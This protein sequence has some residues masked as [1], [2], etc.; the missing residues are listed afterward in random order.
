MQW[1]TAPAHGTLLLTREPDAVR[2][3][4]EWFRRTLGVQ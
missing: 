4:V 3:L 1:L 2:L